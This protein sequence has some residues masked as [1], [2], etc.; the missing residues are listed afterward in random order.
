MS[1][2]LSA[3]GVYIIANLA[4][5]KTY[6][7]SAARSFKSRFGNHLTRLRRGS[8][9]SRH[10]QSAWSK[11]GEE[12]FVF[13]PVVE[14]APEDCIAVEQE[15]I[16]GWMPAYNTAKV[17]GST[18]G[19]AHA[20]ETKA[21]IGEV[22][23]RSVLAAKHRANLADAKRGQSISLE[24]RAKIAAAGVGK[25]HSPETRAKMSAARKEYWAANAGKRLTPEHKAKIAASVAKTKARQKAKRDGS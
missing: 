12:S 10:L 11:Y 8:H 16:D 13:M 2:P 7:G 23:R 19:T 22:A 20:P 24:H 18:L 1:I 3:T 21:K 15:W 9:H 4:N 25:T 14:V 6:I 17:A 5:G